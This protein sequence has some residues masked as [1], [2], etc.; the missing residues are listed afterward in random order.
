MALAPARRFTP[1]EAAAL[2]GVGLQHLQNALTRRRIVGS[3]LGAD[4][5]RGIDLPTMMAFAAAERMPS[6]RI[7]PETLGRAFRRTKGFPNAAVEIDGVVTIDAP[8]L[9]APIL[10]NLELYDRARSLVTRDPAVMGGMPVIKG[11]RI[12]VRTLLARL[13][14]GDSMEMILE[15]YPYLDPETVEAAA[16]YA[17]ANPPVAP[18]PAA[19]KPGPDQAST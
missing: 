14:G 6:I 3:G 7:A 4:G 18:P 1:Q 15:D 8:R 16:L 17:R 9:L 12:P 5:R 13:E 19:G 10:R 11:T 2:I